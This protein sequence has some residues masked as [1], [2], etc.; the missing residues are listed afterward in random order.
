[1]AGTGDAAAAACP[2][3]APLKLYLVQ[4]EDHRA[5]LPK[6]VNPYKPRN[7][8]FLTFTLQEP[9]LRRLHATLSAP[10]K[11]DPVRPEYHRA[12]L[13]WAPPSPQKP[14]RPPPAKAAAAG[15]GP[16]SAGDDAVPVDRCSS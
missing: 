3:S 13:R 6:F 7:P 4:P 9:M 1:M 16:S 8:N 10:L 5:A 15:G 12:A 2:L 14:P 11:L